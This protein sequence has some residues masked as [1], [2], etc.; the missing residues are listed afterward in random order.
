MDDGAALIL[1]VANY[2]TP[3]NKNIPTEGVTPTV[4]VHPSIDDLMAQADLTPACRGSQLFARRSSREESHRNPARRRHGGEESRKAAA[5]PAGRWPHNLQSRGA[6]RIFAGLRR[7]VRADSSRAAAKKQYRNL[8]C[9]PSPAKSSTPRRKSTAANSEITIR[10][11]LQPA[12]QRLSTRSAADNISIS[13]SDP[14]QTSA[15]SASLQRYRATHKLS[16]S[17]TSS[18]GVIRFDFTSNGARTHTIHVVTPPSQLAT[19]RRTNRASVEAATPAPEIRA[20]RSSLTIWATIA[21]P[22]TRFSRSIFR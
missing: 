17:E 19:V 6:L 14:S 10:P 7:R 18:S 8:N 1:T 2:F 11:E 3:G 9:G 13:L 20:S 5:E 16:V 15:L 21:P 12:K 4:E 22:P